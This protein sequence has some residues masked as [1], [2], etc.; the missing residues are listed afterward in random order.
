MSHNSI[1]LIEYCSLWISF[2]RIIIE[3]L[4]HWLIMDQWYIYPN[5]SVSGRMW[6]KVNFL[7]GLQLV[8]ILSFL[9][10]RL[11]VLQRLKNPVCFTIYPWLVGGGQIDSCL[12][13]GHLVHSE[14]ST[15]SSRVWSQI[16]DSILYD[17]SITK[18]ALTSSAL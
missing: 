2:L 11:V 14:M 6:Q 3:F 12:F 18:S 4:I 5:I 13:Q 1:F 7:S 16:S 10:P 9:S 8:W 15:A 17:G